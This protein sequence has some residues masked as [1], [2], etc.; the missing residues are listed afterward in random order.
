MADQRDEGI[1]ET[2]TEFV[3]LLIVEYIVSHIK[4]VAGGV[5]WRHLTLS[6]ILELR[7]KI[8]EGQGALSGG[9]ILTQGDTLYI[10]TSGRSRFL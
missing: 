10:H 1:T 9:N 5:G 6:I 3:K 8:G 2:K 4:A 7:A